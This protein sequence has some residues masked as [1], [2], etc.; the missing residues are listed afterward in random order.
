MLAFRGTNLF[1]FFEGHCLISPVS[2]D[3]TRTWTRIRIVWTKSDHE[4]PHNSVQEVEQ[5]FDIV[6]T[7]VALTMNFIKSK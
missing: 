2:D 6:G 7:T 1:R 5:L 4:T 3:T